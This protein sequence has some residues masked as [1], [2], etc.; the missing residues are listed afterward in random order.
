[1]TVDLPFHS[2]DCA[3]CDI[4]LS[5]SDAHRLGMKPGRGP[6]DWYLLSTPYSALPCTCGFSWLNIW[7]CLGLRYFPEVQPSELQ[8]APPRLIVRLC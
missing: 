8:A 6:V 1:M 4:G 2:L 7:K 3:I 5:R